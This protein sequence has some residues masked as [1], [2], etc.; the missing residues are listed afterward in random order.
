MSWADLQNAGGGVLQ[1]P[2][3]V[4]V[5]VLVLDDVHHVVVQKVV[6][7]AHLRHPTG[8][9]QGH[10][11]PVLHGLGEVIFG[12]VVPEPLV[13]QPLAAQ[14][15][16]AGEGDIVGVGQS[17]AHVLRQVLILGPVGLVH[18]HD[19]IVPGAEHGSWSAETPAAAARSSA[20]T[21]RW[22]RSRRSSRNSCESARPGPPGP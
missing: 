14:Q 1:Q 17:R 8:I 16:R 3:L 13:G 2:G 7:Q 11:G 22:P 6:L 9:E 10:G 5:Q 18:Q 4:L 15:G 19:D 21:P 20:G 12:N